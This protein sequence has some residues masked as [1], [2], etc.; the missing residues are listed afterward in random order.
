[1]RDRPIAA[2]TVACGEVSLLG[3]LRPVRGLE[4]RLR[5]A[6]RLGFR[7]PSC[8]PDAVRRT[9]SPIAPGLGLEVVA[10]SSIREALA[11]RVRGRWRY[12]WVRRSG[13]RT[14]GSVPMP[15]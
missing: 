4:R 11:Q 10:V 1:M 14:S 8:L 7:G 5:E 9:A 3:E 15:C 6:A 13:T 12:L 2:E